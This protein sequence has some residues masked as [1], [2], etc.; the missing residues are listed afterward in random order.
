MWRFILKNHLLIFVSLIALFLLLWN[1]DRFFHI[2]PYGVV[3]AVIG[4]I[5][6]I[7]VIIYKKI[8]KK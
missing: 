8:N 7:I 5:L 1:L 4:I 2:C 6:E 3:P